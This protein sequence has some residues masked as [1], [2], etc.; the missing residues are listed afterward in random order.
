MA[1][2]KL[3]P[4]QKMINLM[5]LVFIAMLALNMSKEVLGAF[6]L[7]NERLQDTNQKVSSDNQLFLASLEEKATKENPEK[8]GP[9]YQKASQIQSLSDEYNSYLEQLKRSMMEDVKDPTDYQTMDKPDFLDNLFFE[10]ENLREGGQ[11]FL[12]KR[13]AYRDQ[14]LAVLGDD[15]KYASLRESVL[16]RF[17]TGDENGQVENRDGNKVDWLN[18]HYEGFPVIASLTKLSFTQA[19]IQSTEQEI[20]KTMLEGQ[21]TSEVAMTNYTTLLEQSKSAFYQGEQFDG[22]IVL[23]RKDATTRPN[24]VELTLDGRELQ[25]NRDFVIEDGRVKLTVGAGAPGDHNIKG[26]LIFVEGGEETRVPVNATFATITMPNSAV[27]SADKMNVVYRGVENP[28]TISIPGVAPNNVSASAPGLRRQ[29]GS[30]YTL[31]LPQGLTGRTLTINASGKLPD[32]KT[33]STPA[34]FRIKEIPAPTGTI[35]GKSGRISLPSRNLEIATIRA[36]LPD[37]LFDLNVEVSSFKVKIG[38]QPT[39]QVNGNKMDANARRAIQRARRGDV[40]QIFDIKAYIPNNSG[41]KLKE[42]SPIFVEITN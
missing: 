32:G 1:S 28:M 17:N 34:T 3:S 31:N 12:E 5:Y 6:G 20:L 22:S 21:L 26:D 7:M 9:L 37:F 30:K 10:G 39:V 27:I 4:R 41:Y 24:R 33:I 13:I 18:Y 19:D 11:E 14:V 29:S 25:E 38:S 8:Y 23:G 16:L 42:V 40:A 35:I 36:E 15:P 2:G